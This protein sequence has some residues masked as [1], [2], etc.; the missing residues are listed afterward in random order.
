MKKT[1]SVLM[2]W[3]TANLMRPVLALL[4]AGV[5]IPPMVRALIQNN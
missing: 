2:E 4:L 3:K 1:L 5:L